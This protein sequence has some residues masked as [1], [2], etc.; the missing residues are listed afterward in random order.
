MGPV[1]GCDFAA[2]SCR[3]GNPARRQG[4]RR[5]PGC[6]WIFDAFSVGI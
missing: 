2:G 5:V 4:C 1:V 6:Q 3:H